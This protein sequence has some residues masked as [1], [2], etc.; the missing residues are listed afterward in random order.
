MLRHEISPNH[1]IV[2]DG[3]RLLNDDDVLQPADQTACVSTL[4]SGRERWISVLPSWKDDCGKTIKEICDDSG[5]MDG[6]ERLF[7]RKV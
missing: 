4:L 1:A 5:D 3:Y 7:R 6:H 2:G